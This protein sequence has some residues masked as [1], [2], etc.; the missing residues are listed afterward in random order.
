MSEKKFRLSAHDIKRLVEHNGGCIATDTI[1]VDGRPVGYMYR[2]PPHNDADTGW[3]FMAGDESSDYM[4]D[5]GNHGVYAV[6]TIA[7]Y[8]NDILPLIDAPIGSA[9]ARNPET[10]SFEP[11]QSPV[12][13][14][15]CLHP[16]FPVVTGNYQLTPSW[17]IYLPLKFNR[18]VE[19]PSLILWR[20]G[21]T[22][23]LRAGMNAREESIGTRMALLKAD[24]L[25]NA[26]EPQVRQTSAAG[27][28]S[29]RL[30]SDGTNALYG[31]VV[32]GSGQMQVVVYFDNESDIDIARAMFDSITENAA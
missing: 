12:D 13:P 14:D 4:D 8:D 21:I 29:Y 27:Y 18:R 15:D 10:G 22:V 16:D 32:V 9:F 30:F 19:E 20:L 2:E 28:F 23:Y 26:F 25:S 1:T 17:T 24:I 3:R 5:T 31:F 7:N 6:N 11:V